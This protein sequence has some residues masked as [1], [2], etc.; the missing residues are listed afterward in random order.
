MRECQCETGMG[1]EWNVRKRLMW[2]RNG[3]GMENVRTLKADVE[4]ELK[5]SEVHQR[6]EEWGGGR[7]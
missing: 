7:K 6:E 1:M 3:Y 4:E 5:S 2:N